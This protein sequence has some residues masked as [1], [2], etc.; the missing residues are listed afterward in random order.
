[1][2]ALDVDDAEPARAD[3]GAGRDVRAA[4]VRAAVRHRVG[5]P[6]EDAVG[7]DVPRLAPDLDHPA[8]AAHRL[9]SR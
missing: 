7:Q 1:M 5:H 4:V 8:N 2:A 3:R 9:D 6:V